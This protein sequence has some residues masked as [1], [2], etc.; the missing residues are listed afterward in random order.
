M[1]WQAFSRCDCCQGCV[2]LDGAGCRLH[3]HTRR[4]CDGA[5]PDRTLKHSGTAGLSDEERARCR[6]LIMHPAARFP[7]LT[8]EELR[9]LLWYSEYFGEREHKPPTRTFPHLS[10]GDREAVRD[11]IHPG[12][13]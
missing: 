6:R 2:F 7:L 1:P 13:A 3:G 10:P 9:R 4:V 5:C 8:L 12:A 11:F